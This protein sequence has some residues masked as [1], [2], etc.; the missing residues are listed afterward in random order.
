MYINK[1]KILDNFKNIN[2]LINYKFLIC[3]K[4]FFN[5]D[6]II[7]NIGSYIIF[8]F[9]IF[10]I[11]TIIIFKLKQYSLI[12]KIIKKIASE[13]KY[14]KCKKN[15]KNTKSIKPTINPS[16]TKG[17]STSRNEVKKRQKRKKHFHKLNKL[18]IKHKIKKIIEKN[19]KYIDE[20]I[21]GFS[22]I[23]S[24][25]IDKRTYCQYY[26]SLIKTKHNLI[27]AVF[28]KNDYNSRIIKINLFII[29][30]SIKYIVK[31]LFYNDCTMHKIYEE[32]V[33]L[34]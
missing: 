17:I 20:E 9:I 30:L 7:N 13:K 14:Q 16:I 4:K 10:H 12:K 23:L 18:I 21:D 33:Y 34:I 3:Y 29:G 26:V 8:S 2:N 15:M 25:K 1:E 27:N 32:K 5:K 28:N 22:Y 31:T 11:I 6:C 24:L 19:L